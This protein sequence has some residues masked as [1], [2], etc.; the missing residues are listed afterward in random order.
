MKNEIRGCVVYSDT[1]PFSINRVF[2][3]RVSCWYRR[4]EHRRTPRGSVTSI[5]EGA[6]AYCPE[7]ADV[8]CYSEQVPATASNVFEDS[9]PNHSTL[10]VPASAIESY[11]TTA[12]WSKFGTIVTLD[13]D[14][15][16]LQQCAKPTIH[17]QNGQL[18]FQCATEGVEFISE[19]TDS[20]IK[21]SYTAEV[22]LSVTYHISVYATKAGYTDSEAATATLCWIDVEP[23]KEGITGDAVTEVKA[24]PVLIQS[25]GSGLTIEGAEAGTPIRVYDLSGRLIGNTIAVEG[26]TRVNV[27]AAAEKVVIVKVGERSVK[28]RR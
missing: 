5:G 28:V 14:E 13:G 8:Y 21:K 9:Y 15:P 27:A 16:V 17:Y 4:S 12:P 10:H 11:R 2:I 20:D 22:D 18:S 26:A 6:F 23:Q 24:M 1:A 3:P 7:L 19:I 25:E